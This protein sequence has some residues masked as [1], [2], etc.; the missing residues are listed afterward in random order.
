MVTQ[1]YLHTFRKFMGKIHFETCPQILQGLKWTSQEG[2]TLPFWEDS[3][4]LHH[5]TIEMI[6]FCMRPE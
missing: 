3:L 1:I 5:L 2:T 6:P 4:Q